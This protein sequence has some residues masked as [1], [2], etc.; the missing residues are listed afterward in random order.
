VAVS[1]T[2]GVEGLDACPNL[3]QDEDATV[4]IA[5]LVLATKNGIEGCSGS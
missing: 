1:I 3:D 5:E 2:L 4:G